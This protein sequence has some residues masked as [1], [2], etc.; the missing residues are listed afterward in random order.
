MLRTFVQHEVRPVESL[1]GRWD[2]VTAEDRRDRTK[3]PTRYT[4]SIHVPSAWEQLPGLEAYRG[5]AWLRT[6]IYSNGEKDT[7]VRLAFGGVSHTADVHVDGRHVGHHYDAF[8][9]FAVIAR[10]LKEGE[11]ELVV[12]VDNSFGDHSAL[13]RENDYYT[14]GGITR[15]VELQ[16]VPRIYVDKVFATPVRR[17]GRWQLDVRV[18]LA[19]W[20]RKSARRSVVVLTED[21]GAELGGVTVPPGKTAQ[22]TGRLTGLDVQAWS[23]QSPVL[24][25]LDVLLVDG[26]R[27]ADDLIE[28]VGFRDIKVRG[29]KL[30]LNGRP[31]RLRGYNRHE[32]HPQFGCAIPV[33]AMV[34]DLEILRDLG[35][36][37][38]RT[39]HYPNDMRF[40]DLC[41]ELGFC[42]WEESH[43]RCVDFRHPKFRQ[44]I[45]DSTRE[46][47]EWHHNR[48]C[49]VIWGCL[50][51]CDSI[52]PAGRK[53]HARVIDLIRKLDPS[54]PVT[55]ASNKGKDDKCLDL[56]DVVSWNRYVGWYRGEPAGVET[57]LN[58]LMKWLHS[59]AGGG[60]GKPVIMSEFGAGAIP[61]YRHPHRAKWTEQY[62]AEA[63]DAQ[64]AAYLNHP[65]VAGCT[66]WQFADCRITG[67]HFSSR[68]RT[69]NNKGT[70]DEFRRPKLAYD[71]VK[72]RMREAKR[73]WG[74]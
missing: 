52:T 38:I 58:D 15:P 26:E 11:H 31:V 66:I 27:L 37:F 49:I 56:V 51:E 46:M 36:N 23:P 62:Q 39:C 45:A 6:S 32:D 3:L 70:V 74:K 33:E 24:Y 64:L 72:R 7:A 9:P 44:Q 71:V 73:R 34:T 69:M 54:R 61:G 35:C 59:D 57:D 13:H 22:I 53:E 50:N 1:S 30:L 21:S 14:Y 18:R 2:F 67:G 28:R 10:G 8:T 42:V 16:F 43:A 63:L 55:F 29:R 40:L 5:K 65:N 60:R 41:D 4:R 19:N 20:G 48:P 17:G 47:V 68:P 12:E 25:P